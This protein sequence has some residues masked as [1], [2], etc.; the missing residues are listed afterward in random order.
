MMSEEGISVSVHAKNPMF[1]W[2]FFPHIIAA[3]FEENTRNTGTPVPTRFNT[4]GTKTTQT[5]TNVA[6]FNGKATVV[7]YF[8]EIPEKLIFF[9]QDTYITL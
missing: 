9:L 1:L 7:V 6:S 3:E 5:Q 8:S 2:S 4:S